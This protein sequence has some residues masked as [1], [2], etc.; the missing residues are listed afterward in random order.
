MEFKDY[1]KILG[2]SKTASADEIK[3]AYRKLALKYHPDKN[4][5]NKEAEAKFKEISEAYEVLKDS[6]K[7]AKYDNLGS[8][9]SRYRQTGGNAND[10]NW[11][12]WFS[13]SQRG[14]G[15]SSFGDMFDSHSG[16]VSDFFENIFGGGYSRKSGFKQRPQ[17]G[18]DLYANIEI[19]LDDAFHGGHVLLSVNGNKIDIKTKPGMKDGQQLRLS[20]K[21]EAGFYGGPYGDLILTVKIRPHSKFERKDNDLYTDLDINLYDAVLGGTARIDTFTGKLD[22][23]IPAGTSSGKLLK[24]KGQGMPDYNNPKNKGDLFIR[25][26]IIVPEKL[27]EKEKTLFLELKNLLSK[28]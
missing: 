18:K 9:Y 16:G 20:G 21:G 1:Y 6:E 28:R 25:I 5:E 4:K 15:S 24:I 7:R 23:K 13:S 2:V 14:R 10:F 11:N 27:S 12:D 8:S 22:I 26:H 19:S 17:K 3:K